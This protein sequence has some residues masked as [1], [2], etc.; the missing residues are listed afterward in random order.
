MDEKYFG[1][2]QCF[3]C[4]RTWFSAHSWL[5]FGQKCRK[6][7]ISTDAHKLRLLERPQGMDKKNDKRKGHESSL[8]SRC[9]K[10]GYNCSKTRWGYPG[11]P[12]HY[13]E[14]IQCVWTISVARNRNIFLSFDDFETEINSDFLEVFD[15][16]TDGSCDQLNA[17]FTGNTIPANVSSVN[18][19][20]SLKFTSDHN[21]I[22]KGFKISYKTKQLGDCGGNHT[23]PNGEITVKTM[24]SECVWSITVANNRSIVFTVKELYLSRGFLTVY[25][26]NSDK[27]TSIAQL[28]GNLSNKPGHIVSSGNQVLLKLDQTAVGSFLLSYETVQHGCG[29]ILNDNIIPSYIYSPGYPDH[30][31]EGMNCVWNIQTSY[32]KNIFLMFNDL[33]LEDNHDFLLVYEGN[34]KQCEQLPSNFN[35]CKLVAN[36]TGDTIPANMLITDKEVSI[37]LITDHNNVKRGF[38][39]TFETEDM[40]E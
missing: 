17:N 19:R 6:C 9:R 16:P 39:I 33:Q 27:S 29:G 8:C 25:D 24:N 4:L 26:G 1:Q 18:S 20:L 32:V 7:H 13:Y 12:N 40:G 36:Y 37:R 11:Y 14:N 34:V 5:G 28:R 15:C 3:K 30:Y 35:P 10:L 2:Y 22:R 38:N 31:Y 23:K 21:G